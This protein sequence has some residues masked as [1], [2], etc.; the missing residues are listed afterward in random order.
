MN[1]VGIRADGIQAYPYVEFL[2]VIYENS[3]GQN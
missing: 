1:I 3:E 2:L